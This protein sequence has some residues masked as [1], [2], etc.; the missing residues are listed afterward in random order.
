M[1]PVSSAFSLS[2]FLFFAA[3]APSW[4]AG[5]HPLT[6]EALA[7][8]QTFVYRVLDEPSSL[9]PQLA[10]DV[11][12]Q[13]IVRDLFEGLFNQDEN[14]NLVPGVA[15]RYELSDDR[16]TYLF[17]LRDTAKWSNGEPVTATDFVI[18]WRIAALPSRASPK[19]WFMQ[20]MALENVDAVIKG[21]KPPQELGVY[22]VDD[23][24]LEVH[25]STPLPYF[26]QMTT[27]PVTFPVPF[28]V[29][30]TFGGKWTEPGNIVSNGAYVL[31]GHEPGNR[32]WMTRNPLYWD[33][34]H[35]I[36]ERVEA[37]V[38][39]DE[40]AALKS[41][42]FG[43]IDRT[44]VPPKQYNVL[45][46]TNPGQ[47]IS[48]PRLCAYYYS[49]NMSESGP[50]VLKDKR[51]R[52][53]LS[54]AIDRRVITDE[55]LGSGQTEAYTF[56][57]PSVAG[58]TPPVVIW[59]AMSQAERDDAARRLMAKAGFGKD[60]PLH[61]KLLFNTSAAHKEIATAIAN[62]W[63]AKLGVAAE[64]ADEEWKS[65]LQTRSQQN[66]EVARGGWCGDYNEASTFLDLMGSKSGYNDGRYK[67]ARVEALLAAA[68][69][70][71]DPA[72]LYTEIE[73]ILAD[74]VPLIP[75]YH[76]SGAYMLRST[77]ANW[78]VNNVEQKWYSKNLYKRAQ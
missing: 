32:I 70:A 36:L 14:G 22:A 49:F 74:E 37:R 61:L 10:S 48:F 58:F 11:V 30:R 2:F 76:Y 43:E 7:D 66:F 67:N 65:F 59:Q 12:G 77:V 4:A 54:L 23:H 71:D 3:I 21:E 53:A 72:P 28:K 64:L 47:V 50:Q 56:T 33:N 63:K 42:F 75:L 1:R 19:Q 17:H 45:K 16:K 44:D 29:L 18:G 57:P 34:A 15:T 24:T 20:L 26:P 78:P 39:K 31:A 5:V 38:I 9:D 40:E 8:E 41:F 52:R 62:M 60:N 46:K 13:D 69:T 68:K 25:L 27:D 51:V 73:Q 35:T 55:I 6:G